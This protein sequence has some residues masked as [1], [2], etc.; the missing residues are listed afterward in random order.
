ME[1]VKLDELA[2]GL[3]GFGHPLR[4]RLLVL[5]EF[6]A[7]PKDLTDMLTD[8][9]LALVAYHVR[10]LRDYGLIEETRAEPRRGAL[11]HFYRRTELADLLLSRVA[12]FLD[13]PK[14][15]MAGQDRFTKRRED[16]VTWARAHPSSAEETP[17]KLKAKARAAA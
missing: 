7:S 15:R 9:L 11:Q 12:A 14:P 4:I 5:L 6:E 1:S 13:L 17:A 10:M 8:T 2:L 3:S 16:L